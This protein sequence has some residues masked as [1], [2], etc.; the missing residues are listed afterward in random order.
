MGNVEEEKIEY[1]GEG[2]KK[3]EE[4]EG[5]KGVRKPSKQAQGQRIVS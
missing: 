4:S 1:E 5:R 3:I 2:C